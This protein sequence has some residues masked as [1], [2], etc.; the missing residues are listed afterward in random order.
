MLHWC[1][2]CS[3]HDLSL[4]LLGDNPDSSLFHACIP[5]SF[6]GKASMINTH[7]VQWKWGVASLVSCD[8]LWHV[9]FLYWLQC[10]YA[11]VFHK[12]PGAYGPDLKLVK[13]P[14]SVTLW[15]PLI[16]RPKQTSSYSFHHTFGQDIPGCF[17]IVKDKP[18]SMDKVIHDAPSA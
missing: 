7:A 12:W 6:H 15:Y 4:K 8:C 10:Q 18:T 11:T 5:R 13:L 2:V 9:R 1:V 16:C 17:F 3:F 14:I